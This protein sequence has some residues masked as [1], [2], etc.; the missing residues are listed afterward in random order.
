MGVLGLQRKMHGFPA[1]CRAVPGGVGSR[2]AAP[3]RVRRPSDPEPRPAGPCPGGRLPSALHPAHRAGGGAVPRRA[4]RAALSGPRRDLPCR[5][6][7]DGA[8]GRRGRGRASRHPAQPRRQPARLCTAVRA[9]GGRQRCALPAAPR[10]RRH[11]GHPP[12]LRGPL[13]RGGAQRAAGRLE[14]PPRPHLHGRSGGAA[15]AV[16]DHR[17]HRSGHAS[18]PPPGIHAGRHRQPVRLFRGELPLPRLQKRDRPLPRAVAG[19]GRSGSAP[20]LARRKQ[21]GAG[22][23]HLLYGAALPRIFMPFRLSASAGRRSAPV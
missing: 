4:D 19:H 12:E 22:A 14:K 9:I 21:T 20:P 3:E 10:H 16:S 1:R 18:A 5:R 15:G 13:R 17:P 8:A 6:R 2:P 23:L 7:I 11:R